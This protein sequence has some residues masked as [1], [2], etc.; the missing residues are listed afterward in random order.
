MNAVKSAIDAGGA[1]G[2]LEILAG[3]TVLAVETLAYPCG[4]VSGPTLTFGST[5]LTTT[6]SASGTATT[7]RIKDSAG[8]VVVD[9]LTVGTSSANINLASVSLVQNQVL[10]INS[11]TI[12]HS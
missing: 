7:G 10:T 2:T 5:P 4:T 1:A 8:N 9:G 6:V 3:T 12:T 11:A